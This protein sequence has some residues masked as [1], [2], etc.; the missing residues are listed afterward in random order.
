M[1]AVYLQPSQFGENLETSTLQNPVNDPQ[2]PPEE[3]TAQ[4]LSEVHQHL[5]WRIQKLAGI[6]ALDC[7]YFV[8]RLSCHMILLYTLSFSVFT[9]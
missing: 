4:Y 3:F 2:Q 5:A 7:S 1:A 8:E 6:V 9:R